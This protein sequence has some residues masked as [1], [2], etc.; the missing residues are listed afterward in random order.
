MTAPGISVPPGRAGRLWVERRLRVARRGEELLDRKLSILQAELSARRESAELAA[1]QWERCCA[2][3]ERWLLRAALLGGQRSI[4]LATCDRA[5]E[6]HVSYAVTAGVHHPTD[7]T[8][9]I[10]EPLT[11][12][13]P[14]MAEARR[15]HGAALDA[16]VS[17][18]AAAA[19]LRLIEAEA[20]VT[21]YRLH[22]IR[23][24]WIPRLEQARTEIIF[25]LDELERADQARLRRA[26]GMTGPGFV[27]QRN[28]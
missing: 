21:R 12:A 2:D 20:T 16:A 17:H 28:S 25:A 3:A 13:G 9:S 11:W 4:R 8:C 19:A 5:A 27:A 15:A 10:P 6:V 26:R 7:G 14:G 24:R 1:Q 18:A 22:A 23:D